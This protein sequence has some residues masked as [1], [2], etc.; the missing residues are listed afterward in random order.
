MVEII[1]D[2]DVFENYEFIIKFDFDDGF[3]IICKCFDKFCL[4][5]DKE[6]FEVVNDF[7]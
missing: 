6:F 1:V 5:M 3:C 2:F 4:D 7:D